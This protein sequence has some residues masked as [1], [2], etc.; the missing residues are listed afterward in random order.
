[1]LKRFLELTR[2]WHKTR[3]I[4]TGGVLKQYLRELE[5]E[6]EDLIGQ[7]ETGEVDEGHLYFGWKRDV[8]KYKLIP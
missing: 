6:P 2:Q 7:E 3:A 5:Q 8:K 4:G 1:M